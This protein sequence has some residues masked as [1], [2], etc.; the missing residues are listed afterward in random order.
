MLRTPRSSVSFS[1][2]HD[3]RTLVLGQF[4]GSWPLPAQLLDMAHVASTYGEHYKLVVGEHEVA[5]DEARVASLFLFVVRGCAL[6]LLVAFGLF[7]R[8]V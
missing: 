3:T 2:C 7:L 4:E 1:L 8:P 5:L 6:R